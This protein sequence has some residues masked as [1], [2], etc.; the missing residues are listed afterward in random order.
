MGE[1]EKYRDFLMDI[2]DQINLFIKD[3]MPGS[4]AWMLQV[5]CKIA[6][7]VV[8]FMIVSFL[9]KLFFRGCYILFGREKYLYIKALRKAKLATYVAHLIALFLSTQALNSIF[10]EGMH[11]ATKNFLDALVDVMKVV[12]IGGVALRAYKSLEIYYQL[13]SENYKLIALKAISQ[14]LRIVGGIILFFI[15]VSIVF[16]VNNNTLLGSIGAITAVLVLV[17]RDTIL[18]VVT[19]IH[20]ATSRSLKVGDWIGIPKYNLEGMVLDINLLTTKIEN[21]D[22]TISTIPTYDLL[23]TEIRNYQ[24]MSESNKRRIKRAIIFDIKSFRFLT[25]EDIEKLEQINLISTYITEKK[26]EL[27]NRRA[28]VHRSEVALNSEQ[29]TNLGVFREYAYQYLKNHPDVDQEE[30]VLV[31]QLEPSPQGGLPLEIYC[32]TKFSALSAYER[33]QGDIFDHLFSAIHEFGL[34]I[35]QIT[36]IN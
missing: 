34:D 8:F 14:T 15:A 24:R 2:S 12:V 20:V 36:K 5:L 33:V 17:F 18:G 29:L 4:N 9:L 22:K 13:K 1:A 11:P 21:F 16:D 19:G 32:F 6:L 28:N 26:N 25:P 10:Y 3:L 23:S 30:T 35:L 7:L 27:H 31:R